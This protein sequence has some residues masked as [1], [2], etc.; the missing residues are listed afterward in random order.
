MNNLRKS[1]LEQCKDN[2]KLQQQIFS[3]TVPTGGGKTLSSM[4]F[5]LD[6]AVKHRLNR[7]IYAI[8]FTSIIE[9][10]AG[11]YQNIFGREYVL[12]HHCNYKELDEP[13]EAVYN[14]RRGF[15][16]ENWDS[17]IIVTHERTIFRIPFQQQTFEVP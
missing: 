1:I 2:A 7:I 9:Q 4:N 10:N 6:H 15:A 5:A 11:V 16:S 12:E 13:E 17:P 14:R 3:L 8:P